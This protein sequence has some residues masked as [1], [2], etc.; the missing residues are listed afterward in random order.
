M[1]FDLVENRGRLGAEKLSKVDN[2]QASEI[3]E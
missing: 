3:S 2:D 1:S